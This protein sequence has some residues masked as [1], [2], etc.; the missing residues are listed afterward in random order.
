MFNVRNGDSTVVDA[1]TRAEVDSMLDQVQGYA[2]ASSGTMTVLTGGDVNDPI[3]IAYVSMDA[4]NAKKV[5]SIGF[6]W[7][8]EDGD[9][10]YGNNLQ[11]Y[12]NVSFENTT[13][14]NVWVTPIQSVAPISVKYTVIFYDRNAAP[15]SS[16]NK[17]KHVFLQENEY[18]SLTDPDDNTIY[19]LWSNGEEWEFPGEFPVILQ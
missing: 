9:I 13:L 19:F 18:L 17:F 2:T 14:H 7:E 15:I 5:S 3:Y 4:I 12:K 10:I 6:T 16:A 1:Y 8:D 11:Y